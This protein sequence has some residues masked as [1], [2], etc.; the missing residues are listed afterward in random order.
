[1]QQFAWFWIW[2]RRWTIRKTILILMP[3]S[4]PMP[5][6]GA[7]IWSKIGA[8]R[9]AFYTVDS[10]GTPFAGGGFNATLRDMARIGL[11][12]LNDGKWAGEQIIPAQAIASIRN[13]ADK[14]VFAKA[15]YELL[16]GWSYRGM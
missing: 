2:P 12:V 15:G 14:A 6:P 9:E 16:D 7:R 5:G 11:L 3:K 13:G 1:M 10:I 8:E 4:G